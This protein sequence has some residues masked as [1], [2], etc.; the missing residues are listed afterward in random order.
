MGRFRRGVRRCTAIMRSGSSCY[1]EAP[2][3]SSAEVAGRQGT[4]FA[5]NSPLNVTRRPKGQYEHEHM[6]ASM[7]IGT[8]IAFGRLHRSPCTAPA[9]VLHR[10]HPPQPPSCACRTSAGASSPARLTKAAWS[11]G[12]PS[13]GIRDSSDRGEVRGASST[14]ERH[15]P[16]RRA[17]GKQPQPWVGGHHMSRGVVE[18]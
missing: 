4:A 15:P 12:V 10:R 5:C 9:T 1:H 2:A 6:T 16:T 18:L 17:P 7:P 14:L 8:A 11:W 3:P 13:E